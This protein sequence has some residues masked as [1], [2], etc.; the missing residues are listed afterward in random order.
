MPVR[1]WPR[2]PALRSNP[3]C[4]E[5]CFGPDQRR[6]WGGLV[7]SLR[8]LTD[9]LIGLHPVRSVEEAVPALPAS[10][11]EPMAHSSHRP[12]RRP[13]SQQA[14]GAFR[15]D[16]LDAKSAVRTWRLPGQLPRSAS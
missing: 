15:A 2:L 4:Q 16:T 5:V 9:G 6:D 10:V 8:P 7:Q 1:R 14:D 11:F 13:A 12:T 3:G